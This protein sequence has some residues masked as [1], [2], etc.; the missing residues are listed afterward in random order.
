[1]YNDNHA[2]M[3][4]E[5]RDKLNWIEGHTGI[6]FEWNATSKIYYIRNPYGNSSNH[7]YTINEENIVQTIIDWHQ[8]LIT[9]QSIKQGSSGPYTRYAG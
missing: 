9:I 1:M 6:L 8:L 5:I 7:F 2:N 3:P 4:K